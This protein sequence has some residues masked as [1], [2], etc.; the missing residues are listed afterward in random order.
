MK[1]YVLVTTVFI[2]TLITSC[3]DFLDQVPDDRLTLDQTF[4][5]ENTVEQY[6]ANVYSVLPDELSQRFLSNNAGPWTGGSD[7]AE[8]V[9]SFVSSNEM[10]IGTWNPTTGFVNDKWTNFYRG[11][12][13]A[14]YFMQ[15]VYECQDCVPQ[16]ELQY[17]AEARALRAIFYYH[18]IRLF[19]P[20]V[21]MGDTPIPPDAPVEQIHLPRNTFDE[22]VEYIVSELNEAMLGLPNVPR[23]DDAYGRITRPY[24]MAIR[25]QA[26]LLAASPLFNGNPDYANLVNDDGAHL[27]SQG[28]D[29][30]KWGAAAESYRQFITEFVPGTFSLYRKSNSQGQFDPYLSTRDVMLD[31]WNEEIIL[32]RPASDIGSRQYEMTPFHSGSSSEARGSGG[33]GAT[34]AMVDA[35]FM[36]NGRSI[37]D[38]Q[39]GYKTSGF[40]SFRVP[41][42]FTEREIF[43][44]WVD[45]EPRFYASITF[46]NTLWLNRNTGDIITRTWFEGNSGRKAGGNDYSPTGYIARKNMGLGA[47][48][49][50]NRANSMLRLAEIYLDYAEALNESSPGDPEVLEYINLVRNRAGIPEYGSSELEAPVGK[51]AMREAIRKE[52]RVELAFENVRYFDARRWKIAEEVFDGPTIGLDINAPDINNFYN[53][54]PFETRIFDKRHYLW[55]IPQDEINI[56]TKLVQNTGW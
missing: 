45:R 24:A 14:S 17:H 6:L 43:N 26:L 55:P 49:S 37:D 9:W 48:S 2:I 13:N 41:Y 51:D 31:E 54:V 35:Y 53:K 19:G 22:C 1:I 3:N 47:W 21:L 50:G 23:N 4:A 46:D 34:Q 52:R 40:S 39:S 15:N 11:I 27:I 8:Y 29:E 42:D 18:L 30:D 44:Q 5:T 10:N 12:R 38:P 16:L 56:N 20:V 28:Y 36:A 7:E 33:L 25:S 32:A